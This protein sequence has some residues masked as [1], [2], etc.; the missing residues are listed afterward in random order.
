MKNQSKLKLG[1]STIVGIQQDQYI[2]AGV[3]SGDPCN[4]ISR[5][6]PP[7]KK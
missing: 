6:C 1:K 3:N 5:L 7:T 2:K 4:G